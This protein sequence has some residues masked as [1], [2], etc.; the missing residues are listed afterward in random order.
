MQFIGRTNF[1]LYV[2]RNPALRASGEEFVS[3]DAYLKYLYDPARLRSR[4]HVLTDFSLPQI[5][6]ARSGH[7][8]THVVSFSQ[9]LPDDFKEQLYASAV[10]HTFL[11]LDE[12]EDG[13]TPTPIERLGITIE[14]GVFVQYRLDDDDLLPKDYFERIARFAQPN[15]VGFHATLGRGISAIK[16][17]GDLFYAREVEWPKIAIGFADICEL[18]ADGGIRRPARHKGHIVADRTSPV[19]VDS[20]GL[21][22]VWTRHVHQ[23]SILRGAVPPPELAIRRLRAQLSEWPAADLSAVES[24]FPALAGRIHTNSAVAHAVSSPAVPH[25]LVGRTPLPLSFDT[26]QGRFAVTVISKMENPRAKPLALGFD[27]GGIDDSQDDVIAALSAQGIYRSARS[28]IGFYKYLS[29]R[30]GVNSDELQF[31][32]PSGLTCTGLRLQQISAHDSCRITVLELSV[33]TPSPS[34]G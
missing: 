3:E 22:W 18:R 1:S 15:N 9:S 23:D 21:G 33:W 30:E 28:D 24:A 6:L 25:Q 11:Q 8:V 12:V 20:S 7:D 14:P 27:L 17:D 10:K 31:T 2:P 16:R 13:R 32:L 26:P 4:I 34:D 5:E 19:I 29:S